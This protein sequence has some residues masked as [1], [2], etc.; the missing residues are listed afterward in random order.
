[1]APEAAPGIGLT[2]VPLIPRRRPMSAGSVPAVP[3]PSMSRRPVRRA[4]CHFELRSVD[5]SFFWV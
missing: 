2:T 4:P 1:M 3:R 5:L